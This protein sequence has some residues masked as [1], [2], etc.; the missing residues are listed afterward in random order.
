MYESRRLIVLVSSQ[1]KTGRRRHGSFTSREKMDRND[2]CP[3]NPRPVQATSQDRPSS[4]SSCLSCSTDEK[5]PED[6]KCAAGPASD[7]LVS[8]LDWR[9]IRS[10]MFSSAVGGFLCRSLFHP[11]DTAKAIIQAQASPRVS[12]L[13][14][15][16]TNG[17]TPPSTNSSF[18]KLQGPPQNTYQAIFRSTVHTLSTVWKQEGIQ[19]LYRG[20]V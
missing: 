19:G 6:Q 20:F 10:I 1:R 2:Q 15:Q 17:T 3:S 13:S 11:I 5:S 16:R 9:Q 7:S 14:S 12:A 4:S 18:L 8:G